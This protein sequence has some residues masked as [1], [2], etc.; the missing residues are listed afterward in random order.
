[1]AGDVASRPRRALVPFVT[2]NDPSG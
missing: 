1:V 2:M